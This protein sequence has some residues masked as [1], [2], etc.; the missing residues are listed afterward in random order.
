MGYPV[1][2]RSWKVPFTDW[3]K[4]TGDRPIIYKGDK[5]WS[6]P[7]GSNNAWG[8]KRIAPLQSIVLLFVVLLTGT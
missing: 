3:L 8:Q 6:T 5:G 7:K 2:R 4:Q 1:L